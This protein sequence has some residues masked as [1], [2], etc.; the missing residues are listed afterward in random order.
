MQRARIE[1]NFPR[2]SSKNHWG[3]GK[4]SAINNVTR[5]QVTVISKMAGDGGEARRLNWLQGQRKP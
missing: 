2:L 4:P 5:A 3:R 1:K